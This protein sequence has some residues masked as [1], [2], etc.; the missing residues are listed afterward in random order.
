MLA[1]SNLTSL[2]SLNLAQ[3]RELSDVGMRA[4]IK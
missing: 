1:V 3:C 2:K 4:V